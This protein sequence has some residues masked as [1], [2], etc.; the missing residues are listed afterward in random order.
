MD[1]L[2]K[3]DRIT[4]LLAV[5]APVPWR[6]RRLFALLVLMLAVVPVFAEDFG[7]E[8][9]RHRLA[10]N[11]TLTMRLVADGKASGEP[12]LQPLEAD[13][14]IISRG[15]S[16]RMSVVNGMVSHTREWTLELAPKRPGRLEIPVLAWGDKRSRPL[17]VDVLDT[18][19][20]GEDV[21]GTRP[22]FVEV[23]ADEHTP[24][25]QQ[26]FYYRVKVLYRDAPQRATLS[27]PQVEGATLMRD[28]ADESAVQIIDGQQ[29]QVIER[30]FLVVPLKSGPLTIIGP[31]L[32]ALVPDPDARRHSPTSDFDA[33]FGG[34]PFGGM[35]GL[36]PAG[37]RV[38]ERA[39]DLQ[40]QVRPQPPGAATPW[41]PA[42]SI[43]LS[44]EWIPTTPAFQVGEPVTRVLVVTARGVTAA[45]LPAL[46]LAAP[47]GVQLYPGPPRSEDLAG[48]GAPVAT[49]S[50]EV[51]IIP[52]RAGDVTLPEVRLP[53]WDVVAD[54]ERVAIIP[55]RTIQVAPAAAGSPAVA[56]APEVS[57]DI[58]AS[59]DTDQTAS[60]SLTSD[61][62]GS[63]LAGFWRDNAGWLWPALA[64]LLALGWL[65]TLWRQ[66]RPAGQRAGAV[67]ANAVPAS[68]AR[69]APSQSLREAQQRLE[70]ACLAHDA[71]GARAAL[72][73]WGQARWGRDTLPG[74]AALAERL[75][76]DAASRAL[77]RLDRALYAGAVEP[78]DGADAWRVLGPLLAAIEPAGESRAQ[79]ALPPLYPKQV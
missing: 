19:A 64:G 7:V 52:T 11:E 57:A 23:D 28:G 36:A 60:G 15:Q 3:L 55:A 17:V 63:G 12:D 37:R 67:P 54:Q 1:I 13:F 39:P 59:S 56:P 9:D 38:L 66:R 27:D 72:L 43:E 46:D 79:T 75:G 34:G 14:E 30:R 50:Q 42:E 8:L 32:D 4:S 29:Y 69:A 62:A 77:A 35:P 74:L 70:Q 73:D 25:I 20:A 31:R 51:A 24:Y 21:A 71:R 10:A 47:D 58:P 6:A 53:W 78:W 5:A 22:I 65:V 49:A 2:P 48:G 16:E 33:F 18:D 76:D 45:Q 44:D 68:A 41:L 40:I 61:Q 26:P